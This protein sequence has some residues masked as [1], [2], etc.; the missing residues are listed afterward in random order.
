MEG[1]RLRGVWQHSL[2][3]T[4]SPLL[5]NAQNA[6]PG[7]GNAWM[8]TAGPL[9]VACGLRSRLQEQQTYV[10]CPPQRSIGWRARFIQRRGASQSYDVSGLAE[11]CQRASWAKKTLLWS[12]PSCN[13]R[14]HLARSWNFLASSHHRALFHHHH[15]HRHHHN[16]HH[17]HNNH[18]LFSLEAT[19]VCIIPAISKPPILYHIILVHLNLVLGL[20]CVFSLFFFC[21]FNSLLFYHFVALADFTVLQFYHSPILLFYHFITLTFLS[22]SDFVLP[23]YHS[24][25][26]LLRDPIAPRFCSEVLL[27]VY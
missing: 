8:T 9:Y 20:E 13:P 15:H 18:H 7:N 24:A 2:S 3:I 11:G 12:V 26:L 21:W 16:S 1:G 23:F 6:Q 17:H 4:R 22:F 5:R 14:P 25:I 10:I 27:P 19:L